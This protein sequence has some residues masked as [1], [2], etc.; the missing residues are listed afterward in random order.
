MS[1]EGRRMV[2]GPCWRGRVENQKEGI[3]TTTETLI[4]A[5]LSAT[6]ERKET[7]LRMLRGNLEIAMVRA[8]VPPRESAKPLATNNTRENEF[9]KAGFVG[10]RTAAKYCALSPRTLDYARGRGDLPYHKV[11]NKVLFMTKDLDSFMAR[12]RVEV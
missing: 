12:Y 11:G 9:V 4:L 8:V 2:D 5:V 7:V 3:M 6:E 10:K 1:R